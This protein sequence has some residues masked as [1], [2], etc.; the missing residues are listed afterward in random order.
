M[1]N[2][3]LQLLERRLGDRLDAD[4]RDFIRYATDGARRM[5]RLIND[6][7][8]YSRITTQGHEMV[9]TD[10]QL[11]LAEAL[12]NLKAAITE[13]H[14]TIETGPLPNVRADPGQITRLFQNLVGNA[15]KY[16][17]VGR[18]PRIVITAERAG[19]FWRFHVSDNG[20]G[21]AASDFERIF[22][23]FQRLH[24][25]GQYDG[26]GIGLALCKRI[27]ER[28][29]GEIQVDSREGEGS[30]FVFTLPAAAE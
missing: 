5:S 21:I 20:I 1:V 16:R 3:Y 6:L 15:I 12:A 14:A 26:T 30:D 29:G 23:V 19:P 10:C 24:G 8:D 2:S 11:V 13:A 4:A 22:H 9:P 28:H 18:E 7:L 27:V 25:Q 17:S